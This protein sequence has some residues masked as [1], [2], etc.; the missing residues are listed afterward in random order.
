MDELQI[1]KNIIEVYE[2][3]MNIIPDYNERVVYLA[4]CIADV[5]LDLRAE[6]HKKYTVKYIKEE[7]K[8]RT[9]K[10]H[11]EYSKKYDD[12]KK[13]IIR[14]IKYKLDHDYYDWD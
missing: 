7:V 11:R 10:I 13:S 9:E 14:D 1:A 5:F 12:M 2:D 8:K 3:K 6:A 4:R